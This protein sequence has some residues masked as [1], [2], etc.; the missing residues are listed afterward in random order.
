MTDYCGEQVLLAFKRLDRKAFD[1][2]RGN[3]DNMIASGMDIS[4][5]RSQANKRLAAL[6]RDAG[7]AK[8]MSEIDAAA[9][10]QIFDFVTKSFA[11]DPTLGLEAAI[12]GVNQAETGSRLSLDGFVQAKRAEYN[13]W[14]A[15][16]MDKENLWNAVADGGLDE[17]IV[18]EM[19]S[20]NK[21]GTTGVT[22]IDE[23]AK[24]AKLFKELQRRMNDEY[25]AAGGWID[26]I[27]DYLFRQTHDGFKL[28][29]VGF[30]KWAA[31]IA[32]RLD[33]DKIA[34]NTVGTLDRTEFLRQ[35]FL[36]IT[37][38]ART[39]N[40]DVPGY[41]S[42]K[43]WAVRFNRQ[44][45]L[46]FK[47]AQDWFAYNKEFGTGNIRDAIL[48]SIQG[49]ARAIA[50]LREMGTDPLETM[51]KVVGDL[52]A[53][54]RKQGNQKALDKLVKAWGRGEGKLGQQLKMTAGYGNTPVNHTLARWGQNWRD[55]QRISKLG[56]ALIPSI[57]D[58]ST[59]AAELKYQGANYLDGYSNALN[60][61]T[62]GKPS[63]EK[64]LIL[65]EIGQYAEGRI[66]DLASRFSVDQTFNGKM[67]RAQNFFFKINGLQWWTESNTNAIALATAHNMANHTAYAFDNLPNKYKRLLDLYAIGKDEWDVIRKAPQ[68]ADDG[69]QFVTPE[70][71]QLLDIQEFKKLLPNG[72]E[73]ELL[74]VRNEL[75]DKVR[76]LIVDRAKY[77]VV[78]TD[79]R[80]RALMT[81]GTR[82]GT[83]AGE[84][85]RM[86]GQFKGFPIA[87]TQRVLGREIYGKAS[88]Y[89]PDERAWAGLVGLIL[90]STALGYV[91]MTAKDLLKGR[92]P[93]DTS[94]PATWTAAMMQGGG[95]GLYGDFL[96]GSLESRFGHSF[97]ESLAGP[98]GGAVADVANIVGAAFQKGIKGDVPDIETQLFNFA[99]SN[100]PFANLFY[101]KP[102]LDY[103]LLYGIQ[104][105]LNPGSLR[106]MENRI[107]RDQ[108]QE[109]LFP[110]SNPDNRLF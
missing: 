43:Y 28:T 16:E 91:A 51:D 18:A 70:T 38:G 31:A 104:E 83:G 102:A 63:D 81:Q 53:H 21:T 93:R 65:K 73:A 17:L 37:T 101:L 13:S 4:D 3:I 66:G 45:Q 24:A 95:L 56:G 7:Q 50:M 89:T 33:W 39:T 76:R 44:R 47:S 98:T 82:A 96:F 10:A 88:K 52:E 11:N 105:E 62:A 14:F 2:L 109:F 103:G 8:R 74:D 12:V 19:D 59:Q 49:G 64:A 107:E 87:Y 40:A 80:S 67:Q 29:D 61:I 30:D 84:L 35:S 36:S 6:R 58:F 41:V 57:V 9:R 15:Y 85:I 79:S 75:T 108:G 27:D 26:E 34:S 71:L 68:R 86:L 99:R 92:E 106:R 78:N 69:K 5:I 90:Q 20:I 94:N 23:A 60:E 25:T 22:G 42:S 100:T 1:D 110:P 46:H 32:P 48:S 72:S 54:Y 77:G 55:W 97:V